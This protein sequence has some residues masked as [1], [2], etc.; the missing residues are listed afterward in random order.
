MTSKVVQN[1]SYE[2]PAHMSTT[3]YPNLMNRFSYRTKTLFGL[4]RQCMGWQKRDSGNLAIKLLY[5]KHIFSPIVKFLLSK[6]A[7]R[8]PILSFG[9]GTTEP[10]INE[11]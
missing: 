11:L 2:S 8:Q 3:K 6:W 9:A 7:Q 10:A 1:S 4:L 5:L